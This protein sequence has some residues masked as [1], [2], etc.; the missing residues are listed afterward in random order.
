MSAFD[1]IFAFYGLL[2]GLAIAA[3]ASGYGEQWRR[4]RVRSIGWLVPL[5]GCYIL[6]SATQQWLSFWEGRGELTITARILFMSLAMALPYIFVAQVMFPVT[7]DDVSDGNTHYMVDRRVFLGVLI[8]PPAFS[9]T[10]N[11]IAD[12]ALFTHDLLGGLLSWTLPPV[13]LAALIFV[14]SRSWQIAGLL[15]LIVDRVWQIV[16]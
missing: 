6:L 1:A 16:L 3:V 12:P 8:L 15:L 7:D 13:V 11:L 9:L 5:L 10:F 2:L 14:R 4:R